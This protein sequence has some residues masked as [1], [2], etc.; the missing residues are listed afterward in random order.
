M[1]FLFVAVLAIS[2]HP[3]V[4]TAVDEGADKAGNPPRRLGQRNKHHRQRNSQGPVRYFTV[5]GK[6]KK[7]DHHPHLH[8]DPRDRHLQ[9]RIVG[10][11]ESDVGEF[12]YYVDMGGCGGT[13]IAPNVVMSAAHCGDYTGDTIIV[14]AVKPGE[15]SFGATEVQ[16]IEQI[17]HPNHV[18]STDENDMNDVMLMRISPPVALLSS[19]QLILNDEYAI[20]SNGE[21]LSVIGLG[22]LAENGPAA[23]VLMDVVVQAID[24]NQC[25][26]PDGYDGD[27]FDDVMMCAGVQGGGKDGCY[28]D[29]GGPLVK[30]INNV[31][32]QVGINSWGDGCALPDYPGVYTRV[33]GVYDF[34]TAVVCDQWQADGPLC[35]GSDGSD[36]GNDNTGGGG[37]SDGSD[38]GNDNT[39]GGG[40]G[41]S[42]GNCDSSQL[43]FEFTIRTDDYGGETSWEVMGNGNQ[44]VISG[45]NYED[46]R[47]YVTKTCLPKGCYELEIMDDWGDGLS[48]GGRNPGYELK[49]DG[50]TVAQ[51]G[52]EDFGSSTTIDF[53]DCGG[54]SGSNG[55]TNGDSSSCIP[56]ELEVR[57]DEYGDETDFFLLTN[58]GELIWD[59]W[60]FGD[61][62]LNQF[63]TCLERTSCATL[64]IFDS[65]GDGILSPGKVKLTVDGTVKYNS[66]DFD[67]GIIFRIGGG[68]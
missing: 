18:N 29:S 31:H 27:V 6:N 23:T 42:T 65:Y 64:D 12:P 4:T 54:D 60:G 56:V 67:D 48:E 8:H 52:G 9:S 15:T 46:D 44:A 43:D 55:G 1:K 58:K 30:R 21:D 34:I 19:V 24:T 20:P 36:N 39:D 16:V 38:S 57:T 28:G 51:A 53:G 59:E 11:D 35:G 25:N 14:G 5:P 62:T 49:I 50:R 40:G 2:F 26:G 33:S 45:G 47:V 32:L 63:S 17:N 7:G 10:G 41:D 3:A 66:G 13:L 22:D 37:G 61:N 68:C